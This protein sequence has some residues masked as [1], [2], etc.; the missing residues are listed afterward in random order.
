[1]DRR[2]FHK[3]CTALISGAAVLH[4]DAGALSQPH[5]ASRL[6]D[7][8]NN[9]LTVDD[10][11]AGSSHVFSYPYVTT[12][13]F[14]LR[15]DA[16][17]HGT[18]G[19]PGGVGPTHDIVAFSAICSHKMTHPARP[20]SHISFRDE[21]VRFIEDGKTTERSQLISCC[22][23]RSVYDPAR[24]AA[25]L[26]GP[27]PLPLAAIVLAVDD[28]GVLS[29]VGSRGA[30]QYERFLD[31]FGFRLALEYGVSDVR[32]RVGATTRAEPAEQFS[33]QTVRC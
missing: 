21:P 19:W 26:S 33:R 18:D 7:T 4:A 12:P 2:N 23:E 9:L 11:T 20:I 8:S 17:V 13:C 31:K 14:L 32:Q 29:A 1:M 25:V 22:S 6:V 3:L 15:L 27:A 24:G 10:L 16:P 5:P 30:D 28:D